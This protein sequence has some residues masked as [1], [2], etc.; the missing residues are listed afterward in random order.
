MTSNG[1]GVLEVIHAR[2]YS[3]I[4]ISH[5]IVYC[6][7]LIG[8]LV[9]AL[10]GTFRLSTFQGAVPNW[11]H[12]DIPW[13]F[14]VIAIWIPAIQRMSSAKTMVNV[15]M[16]KVN[17]TCVIEDGDFAG[18]WQL[19]KKSPRSM[20]TMKALTIIGLFMIV[21]IAIVNLMAIHRAVNPISK[22]F[23][24]QGLSEAGILLSVFVP[25]LSFWR[26]PYLIALRQKGQWL[27]L[28]ATDLP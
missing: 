11:F 22:A 4:K 10:T 2:V 21:V 17:S 28:Q 25:L 1:E 3:Y 18:T 16:D 23:A 19:H 13:L 12:F 7:V 5:F 20:S 24:V 27:S 15:R 6:L 9:W 8:F 14:L 26:Y